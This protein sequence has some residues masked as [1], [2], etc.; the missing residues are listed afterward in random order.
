MRPEA[1]R[2]ERRRE[3]MTLRDATSPREAHKQVD[4][5]LDELRR[6]LLEGVVVPFLGAGISYACK[7]ISYACK[8]LKK[9][10]FDP[11]T[12][13]LQK[14]LAGWLWGRCECSPDTAKRAGELLGVSDLHCS[15]AQEAFV[16]RCQRAS[17][18]KLAEVCTWLSDSRTVCEVLDIK[19][20]TTL[21]PRPAHRYVAYLVRE[22]LIDEVVTTNWDTCVEEALKCSFGPRLVG[23]LDG[24]G[25]GSPSRVIS[26]IGEY[27]RWGAYRRRGRGG[28]R[29]PVLRLYKINGCAAAYK[30]DP[31]AEAE[32]I[33]LT[34]RQLQGFRDNHWAADLFRDRARSHRLLFSGFGSEEPQIRHAVTVL[35]AEFRAGSLPV[36]GHAPFVQAYGESP[37]F[38]QYQLL[39]AYYQ[40]EHSGLTVGLKQVLTGIHA[41]RF[42]DP[43]LPRGRRS[44][45]CPAPPDN[46]LDADRFWFGVYLA[47]MRGLVE[48]YCESPFPFYAWL[49]QHSP[50]PAR[51][52]MRF[53]RWLYPPRTR[54][55][56]GCFPPCEHTFGRLVGLFRPTAQEDLAC[57]SP[58]QD[59][60]CGPMRL[61]VWLAA[62]QGRRILSPARSR[63]CRDW[64]LPMREAS[65]LILSCLYVLMALVPDLSNATT[66]HDLSAAEGCPSDEE[67]DRSLR[68]W[69][70]ARGVGLRVRISPDTGP[71]DNSA[72]TR[73]PFDVSIV[74]YQA[75]NPPTELPG[76]V[77]LRA[78]VRYELAVSNR[79]ATIGAGVLRIGRWDQIHRGP[80]VVKDGPAAS[81]P[82]S[83]RGRFIRLPTQRLWTGRFLRLP[84]QQ[85]GFG[86][87]GR[88]ASAQE[89]RAAPL[90]GIRTVQAVRLAAAKLLP[91]TRVRLILRPTSGAASPK[92]SPR[93]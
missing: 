87:G 47:A 38:H 20:F 92:N 62:I 71:I 14:S 44:C 5:Y 48:R 77:K 3:A 67:D 13:S 80:P 43:R 25:E 21:V 23:C 1:S 78:R 61:W 75:P 66:D 76:P 8:S 35:A 54:H 9:P 30:R 68:V 11:A 57:G 88:D 93:G 46:R 24:A 6:C 31:A 28:W 52:A 36:Y 45:S 40:E 82:R 90:H 58:Y 27:R 74:G 73:T 50:A 7:S 2:A 53:S 59:V 91:G 19:C 56:T 63:W 89:D 33:A 51:E 42:P 85:V 34:E 55:G 65:L 70:D 72:G 15:E 10:T 83:G 86:N 26:R 69:P 37:T 12:E 18:A 32:R 49:A 81:S 79:L 39:R 4:D 41:A 29:Q 84:T 22:G 60:G 16:K 64:Y 17:L